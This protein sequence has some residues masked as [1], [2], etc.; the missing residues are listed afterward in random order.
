M[1]M[2]EPGYPDLNLSIIQKFY[3]NKFFENQLKRI[4]YN[5]KLVMELDSSDPEIHYYTN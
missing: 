2:N 5:K 1:K 3:N 4:S